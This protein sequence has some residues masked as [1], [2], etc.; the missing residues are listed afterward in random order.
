VVVIRK[1]ILVPPDIDKRVRRLAE[2]RGVSQSAIIVEAVRG[3]AEVDQDV[4]R[5]ISFPGIDDGPAEALSE[6]V[7]AI[8]YGGR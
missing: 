1:Q 5:I 2:K 4:E 3:M 7:D 8:L 6:Q